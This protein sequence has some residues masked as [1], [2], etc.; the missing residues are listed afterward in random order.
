MK[1]DKIPI[2]YP[3]LLDYDLSFVESY[4]LAQPLNICGLSLSNK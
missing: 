2:F 1:E 4:Q 3:H